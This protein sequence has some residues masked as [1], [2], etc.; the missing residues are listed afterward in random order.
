ML[1][2]VEKPVFNKY[3]YVPDKTLYPEVLLSLTSRGVIIDSGAYVGSWHTNKDGSI[4]LYI[5]G[6]IIIK[7]QNSKEVH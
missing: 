2:K 7:S 3:Q 4:S 1:P 6:E 5:D